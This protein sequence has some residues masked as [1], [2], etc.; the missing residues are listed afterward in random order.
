MICYM[1]GLPLNIP[2]PPHVSLLHIFLYFLT[3]SQKIKYSLSESFS[4][5]L[6]VLLCFL[7]GFIN[8]KCLKVSNK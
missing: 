3:V 2:V 4:S 5:V 1:T 7:L 8:V 6:F